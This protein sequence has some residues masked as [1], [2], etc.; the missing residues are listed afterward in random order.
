MIQLILAS[1]IWSF[2]FGIIKEQIADQASSFNTMVRLGLAFL[3]F[4]PFLRQKFDRHAVK[5]MQIGAVQYGLMYLFLFWSFEYLNAYEVALFT[6]FTPFW[7]LVWAKFYQQKVSLLAVILA[8]FGASILRMSS[9]T[10]DEFDMGF[11]LV[12]LSNLCFASG[13]IQYR[14]VITS[15]KKTT[16]GEGSSDL[17]GFA[18]LYLGGFSVSL[19]AWLLVGPAWPEVSNDAWLAYLY[20]GIVASGLGFFLWNSGTHRVSPTALAVANNLKIPTAVAVS[21]FVFGEKADGWSLAFAGIFIIAAF[22]LKPAM[23]SITRRQK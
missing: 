13:Q 19:F 3:V 14:Q 21:L 1:L 2:S 5:L 18:W 23:E 11:V 10:P 6:I 7:V 16:S 4:L 15:K 17:H 22:F 9:A 20:L 12:Q 8:I